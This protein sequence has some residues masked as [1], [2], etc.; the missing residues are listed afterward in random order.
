M[1]TPYDPSSLSSLSREKTTWKMSSYKRNNDLSPPDNI[2]Y[3]AAK[4]DIAFPTSLIECRHPEGKIW[5]SMFI[6]TTF[7]G[8]AGVS[9]TWWGK[10]DL[11]KG[12]VQYKEVSEAA[13]YSVV[14]SKAIAG[15]YKVENYIG[16]EVPL[17][18]GHEFVRDIF[19]NPSVNC[20]PTL[21]FNSD[22]ATVIQLANTCSKIGSLMGTAISNLSPTENFL[23]NLVERDQDVV[24]NLEQILDGKVI[25]SES[26]DLL[27]GLMGPL[28]SLK[29]GHYVRPPAST[30]PQVDREEIYGE[31][32]WGAFG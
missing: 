25:G 6:S 30:A 26:Y 10:S 23:V 16:R 2:I 28:N 11:V 12:Q 20:M 1:I 13:W 22:Q 31:S 14:K 27:L 8:S 7:T 9:I 24:L 17:Q 5:R 3:T 15:G 4:S 18:V 32:G 29:S 21:A 19:D